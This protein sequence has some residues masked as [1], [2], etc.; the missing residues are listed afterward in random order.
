MMGTGEMAQPVR[1]LA[2]KMANLSFLPCGERQ[3]IA[4]TGSPLRSMSK[5]W[6]MALPHYR[7]TDRQ[8]DDRQTDR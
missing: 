6:H 3:E 2:R 4:P 8:I 5:L 1:K 7:Q